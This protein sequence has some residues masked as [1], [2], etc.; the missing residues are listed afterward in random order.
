MAAFVFTWPDGDITK[1]PLKLP[2]V[3]GPAQAV[4]DRPDTGP[5]FGPD[6]LRIPLL[7]SDPKRVRSLVKLLLCL[8][9]FHDVS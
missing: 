3:G 9:I 8:F 1:Q 2:K 5:L 7:P 6:G 4:L